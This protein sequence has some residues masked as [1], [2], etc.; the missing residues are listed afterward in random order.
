MTRYIDLHT[1]TTTSDG[2]DSPSELVAKAIDLRLAALA[3][4]DHDTTAGLAE[5]E[6]SAK[7]SD[8]ELIRGCEISVQAA[9]GELH[10]LGLWLP[11]DTT[12]LEGRLHDI[13]R[14]RSQRNERIVEKLNSLGLDISLDDVQREAAGK[15]VGRPHIARA[16]IRA[17][18]VPDEKAAFNRYL[19]A[20]AA[21]Y[22]PREVLEPADGVLLLTGMGATVSLAHPMLARCPR[23]E[24]E[25]MILLLKNEGLDA[26]E[27]WHS[28]HSQADEAYL[29]ALAKRLD[30][31]LSGGSD[32][33]GDNKPHVRL[34][35]GHGGLRIG[36]A[37]LEALKQ[38]RVRQGLPV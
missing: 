22:V 29:K 7:G 33:H 18:H 34:G 16:L 9:F 27:V 10:L 20:G 24:L 15:V 38:R 30:L 31:G 12:P 8:L 32:F 35:S 25:R 6:N 36:E 4:T 21:G 5:A 19:A 23:P 1:H 14:K 11:Q 17:G 26:L 13:L 2:T 28:E 37:V 3:V